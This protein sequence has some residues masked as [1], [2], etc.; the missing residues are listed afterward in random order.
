ME[1]EAKNDNEFITA[2]QKFTK[3]KK[4]AEPLIVAGKNSFE[5]SGAKILFERAF[6]KKLTLFK[7][8]TSNPTIVEINRGINEFENNS[9]DA[10]IA[11]GGG[12]SLDIGKSIALLSQQEKPSID[13]VTKRRSISQT[14]V[15]LCLVPTTAGTG[16]ETTQFS[17]VYINKSKYSLD[18]PSL[19]P[20][21]AILYPKL[22][23]SL[24][25]QLTAITGSDALAQAME[26]YWNINSNTTSDSFATKA[27][28]L[29]LNNLKQAV[30]NEP[31]ARKEM[32]RG[33]NLAGKAINITRTTAPHA[34]SYFLT[35][36]YTIPHG[37]AVVVTL[38][39]FLEFNAG[40]SKV[41]TL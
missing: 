38:P 29:I 6:E 1:L 36:Y 33:S 24:S 13:Y 22:T 34:I 18:H 10:V 8:F 20:D 2:I 32:L 9:C 40:V 39:S 30:N 7:D 23:F 19:L 28:E 21:F 17:V 15:P 12:S 41:D 16:S 4:I 26:A 5:A 31:R 14:R 3:I 37:Q 25:S 11:V 27:L 35:S